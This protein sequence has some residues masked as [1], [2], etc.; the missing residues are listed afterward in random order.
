MATQRSYNDLCGA[1]HALDLVGERW[2]LLVVREL[3]LG[4]KRYRDLKAD[5]PGISTNMLSARLSELTKAGIVRR[6][7]LPPPARVWVYEL[8]DWGAEL[9]P[10][11]CG[12]A[13]WGF[14]SPTRPPA[15]HLSLASLILS[16]RTNF[17]A[18]A[19]GAGRL[20]VK[21]VLTDEPFLAVID[22][23]HCTVKRLEGNGEPP[24]AT[25]EA[26]R[27][28]SV[29]ALVYGKRDVDEAVAAGTVRIAGSRE[30]AER[31]LRSFTMPE[32]APMPVW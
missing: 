5:L 6:Y 16:L 32:P 17:D 3:M 13:R 27:P 30:A 29:A 20:V 15:E 24:E 25:I 7:R 2:A 14:R 9:E 23:G 21:L 28:I 22:E 12:L 18:D 4:P 31:F 19:A 1:G 10:L 26:D 8:T 11:V